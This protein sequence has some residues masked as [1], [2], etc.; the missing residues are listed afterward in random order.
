VSGYPLVG[1]Y[2]ELRRTTFTFPDGTID[3]AKVRYQARYDIVVL[4][5]ARS[6]TRQEILALLRGYNPGATILAYQQGGFGFVCAP[7]WYWELPPV[8]GCDTTTANQAWSMHLALRATN[9]V[10]Y[11][12]LTG[13]AFAG[14]FPLEVDFAKAG[15]AR[16]LADTIVN[17]AAPAGIFSGVFTDGPCQTILWEQAYGDSIDYA[18]SGYATLAAWDSAYR[19]GVRTFFSRLGVR[20]PG[21]RLVGN[22]G[23]KGPQ[24]LVHGWM[25]ENFPYQNPVGWNNWHALLNAADTAYV[26]PQLSFITTVRDSLS[27]TNAECQRRLRFGLATATLHDR[28]VHSLCPPGGLRGFDP[29]AWADEFSVSPHGLATGDD[30]R[31]GWLGMP[32]GPAFQVGAA[33]RRDFEGG[34][35]LVNP[36][37]TVQA[38]NMPP[39][40]RRILGTAAPGVNTGDPAVKVLLPAQDGLFLVR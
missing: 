39:G 3:S 32:L 20:L 14:Q 24:D 9:G 4:E 19:A 12:K 16:A 27:F 38:V 11:S 31:K 7:G 5:P 6:G 25:G 33:W 17:W 23:P 10:L 8:Y 21:A 34:A 35:V 1:Q 30:T 40:Y 18:R 36:T 29:N 22:C 37:G 13:G 15:T 28:V 26:T 2:S